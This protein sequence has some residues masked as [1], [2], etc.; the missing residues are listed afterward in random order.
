MSIKKKNVIFNW[1][2]ELLAG[3]TQI[4]GKCMEPE[5]GRIRISERRCKLVHDMVRKI[6]V[7]TVG[8][9]ATKTIRNS[10]VTHMCVALLMMNCDVSHV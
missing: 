8:V 1:I 2:L 9:T 7:T 3:P 5:K 10:A 4:N 6:V